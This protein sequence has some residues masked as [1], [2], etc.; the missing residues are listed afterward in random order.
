MIHFQ[1]CHQ[2]HSFAS[3]ALGAGFLTEGS[4]FSSMTSQQHWKTRR[5]YA[6]TLWL[7]ERV[8]VKAGVYCHSSP[9]RSMV[10]KRAFRLEIAGFASPTWV[11]AMTKTAWIR[12]KFGSGMPFGIGP[13]G[14]HRK[15]TMSHSQRPLETLLFCRLAWHMTLLR[16]LLSGNLLRI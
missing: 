9:L 14:S 11:L 6:A 2:C 13:T 7:R 4:W 1:R 10:Y 8:R 16:G 15:G 12:S 3:R 5:T